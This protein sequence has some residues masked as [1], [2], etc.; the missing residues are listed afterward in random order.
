M[1]QIREVLSAKFTSALP[2]LQ[3]S[4]ASLVGSQASFV[5]VQAM[6]D[7][8]LVVVPKSN[9]AQPENQVVLAAPDVYTDWVLSDL[10]SAL[11][12]RFSELSVAGV[13]LPDPHDMADLLGAALPATTP[14][15]DPHFA[16]LGPFYNSDGARQQLGNITKQAVDSRRRTGTILA[17]QTQDST[18]LYPAWQFTGGGAIHDVLVPV[19]RALRGMDRWQSG[20]W[21]VSDHPD[22]DGTSPRQAL[23]EGVDPA[24]VAALAAADRAAVVA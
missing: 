13:T 21:L 1:D 9:D 16:D 17:M 12:D 20:V 22:L 8:D 15:L 6:H 10:R 19:L 11:V 3:R 2:E 4:V 23:R 7:I 5:V 18:W 14:D 24:Q